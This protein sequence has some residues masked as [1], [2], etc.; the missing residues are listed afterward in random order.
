MLHNMQCAYSGAPK[1]THLTARM[2]RHMMYVYTYI[3]YGAQVRKDLKF[4]NRAKQ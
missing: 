4:I 1:C 3:M 2:Y